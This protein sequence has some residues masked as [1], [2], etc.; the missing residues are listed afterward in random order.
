[1]ESLAGRGGTIRGGIKEGYR[2]SI[3]NGKILIICE[4][5]LKA[6]VFGDAARR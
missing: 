2:K 1:M 5:I 4:I 6:S 3:G